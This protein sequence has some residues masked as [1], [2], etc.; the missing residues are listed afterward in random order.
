MTITRRRLLAYSV[1]TIA[2]AL[3]AGTPCLAAE[4]SAFAP[5]MRVIIDND[6]SGDPDGLVQ[7]AHHVLSPS[8]S[9]PLI[10]GSH[11][12]PFQPW[13]KS[14][15]QASDAAAKARALLATLGRA[16][17]PPVV[18]GAERPISSRRS[19]QPSAASRAIVREA[20]RNDIATPLYYAA[21]GGLTDLALAWLAE[22]KIETRLKLVWIGGGEHPGLALPPPGPAEAE[23]NLMT[24]LLAAQII[25]NESAIEI[26]QVP[27]DAY[28]QMLMS[29]A[30]L[31]DLAADSPLGA[32][33]K[34]E[35]DT[36]TATIARMIPVPSVSETWV[37][38]DNPL[39]TLTA[40]QS[41]FQPDPSSS[42]YV[43]LPTPR[44]DDQ[45]AY[46][47]RPDARPM[48]VY[49]SIDAGLT[50]RDMASKFRQSSPPTRTP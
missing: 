38:G 12:S 31:A 47:A 8:V 4:G 7:L 5:R 49:T 24:D 26:W 2:A 9:I 48:R 14:P 36:I 3:V 45:G 33:L 44:L 22:P 30:E 10:V 27:R 29:T 20:M 19:W 34:R 46:Q 41:S 16:A 17:T 23:Y 37:M 35:I 11:L 50:F 40:L 15:H 43:A 13:D 42:R 25:F 6:F 18:A 28:R 39:V 32:Y 21:G 1:G